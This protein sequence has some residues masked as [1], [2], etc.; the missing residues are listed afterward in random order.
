MLLAEQLHMNIPLRV[1]SDS[2][3]HLDQKRDGGE[4]A[5]PDAPQI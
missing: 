4:A 2:T 3:E 1:G 5:C